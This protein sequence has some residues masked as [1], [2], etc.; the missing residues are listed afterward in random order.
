MHIMKS[1]ITEENK[2]NKEAVVS[3]RIEFFDIAAF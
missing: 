2:F 3:K 1:L